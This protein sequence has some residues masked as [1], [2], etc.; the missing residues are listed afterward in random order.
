MKKIAPLLLVFLVGCTSV[1]V[2]RVERME[3]VNAAPLA[4]AVHFDDN[5]TSG[6]VTIEASHAP[7]S[8]WLT[9]IW[10]ALSGMFGG[11]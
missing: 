11:S 1:R 6:S 8:S 9:A 10:A 7:G 5:V 3:F 4:T 2:E